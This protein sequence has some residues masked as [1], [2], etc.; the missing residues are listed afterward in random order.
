MAI[1]TKE[2][3]KAL[4]EKVLALSKADECTLN[5]YGYESGN[6]R[7][8]RNSVSTSGAES[9]I[10]LEIESVFGK[11]TGVATI[12]EFNDEALAR[13]VKTSEELAKLS[14]ENPE[15]MSVLEPQKYEKGIAY[16]ETTANI[17]PED[18]TKIAEDSINPCAEKEVTAAGFMENSKSF[19]AMMNSKKLFAYAQSTDMEF[20]IT[21]RTADGTGSGYSTC[22]FNDFSLFSAKKATQIALD[23]AIESQ[24]AKA[25]EP[26]KYTVI[27]EPAASVGLIRNMMWNFNARSAD[28]GRSFLA[29]QGGGNKLGEQI[30]DKRVN[31]YSDPFN[32]EV[33]TTTWSN[34]L[35]RKKISWIKD[36][37]VENLRYSRFWA[38]EKGKEATAYPGNFIMAGGDATLEEMIKSTKKGIL[39][40]RTWYI[41]TVDPQTLLYTGLT[42]DG[43]FYVEDGK[44]KFPVKN[45]RFNE[46]PVIMLNNVE[47]LGKPIRIDGNLVP[48]MKIRD[49]TFSSLSD[50]I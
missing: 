33:P 30:V 10:S 46:S 35:P 4:L 7:Y 38:K 27:L 42:R 48:P 23:K 18:R 8:A 13:I 1:L 2:E 15:Y 50:A 37:K 32:K 24:N 34:G 19:K 36:G 39:V 25:I 40:T 20:S 3:A 43:T 5:L 31:I 44:I 41:R 16:K 14:P 12:N 22:D 29:K 17:T 45:F 11:K 21:A 9:N 49:F 28:E 47:A 6:I 26:G